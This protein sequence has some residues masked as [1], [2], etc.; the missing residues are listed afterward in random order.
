M[1]PILIACGVPI[2]FDGLEPWAINIE[3]LHHYKIL[4]F[5]M[6]GDMHR[7]KFEHSTDKKANILL[8]SP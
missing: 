8:P 2:T 1:T 4:E 3:H 7:F 5:A 6:V